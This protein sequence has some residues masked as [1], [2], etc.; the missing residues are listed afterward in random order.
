MKD[1]DMD[2]TLKSEESVLPE[3]HIFVLPGDIIGTVEEFIL[4]NNT[5]KH[6]GN[7]YSTTIGEV[8]INKKN[9]VIS[10][11]PKVGIPPMIENGDIVIGRV[12]DLKNAIALV[13]IALIEGKGEREIVN[14]QQAAIHISNV[15]D[16][17]VKDIY[18]EFSQFDIIKAKVI[19]TKLMRLSTSGSNLGVI[20]AYCRKCHV[21]LTK[22]SGNENKRDKLF[23]PVCGNYESRKLSSEYSGPAA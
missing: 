17:Y 12:S 14:N 3:S 13:E 8:N 22:P 21:I 6:G 2:D 16:K 20:K 10:V 9:H 1:K 4:G 18:Y 5:F 7:V 15:K 23:C 11:I 19:D